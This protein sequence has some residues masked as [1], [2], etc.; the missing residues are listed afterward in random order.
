MA[1]T[2]A[3]VL[4]PDLIQAHD[5]AALA[6]LAGRVDCLL[7]G[8]LQLVHKPHADLLFNGDLSAQRFNSASDQACPKIITT[9]R[10]SG[11]TFTVTFSPS[12]NGLDG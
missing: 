3:G 6:G 1:L 9:L 2:V 5:L 12:L 11:S 7:G 10:S 8:A 4:T